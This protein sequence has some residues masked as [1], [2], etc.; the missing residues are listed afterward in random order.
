MPGVATT[1]ELLE[2][3]NTLECKA[4]REVLNWHLSVLQSVGFVIVHRRS[5][6]KF[7]V[8]ASEHPFIRYAYLEG[9]RFKDQY[10]IMTKLRQ[11]FFINQALR[12]RSR[13]P[14]LH[15]GKETPWLAFS[16]TSG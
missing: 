5:N 3:L 6:Q 8:S 1:S 7:F 4:D 14:Q 15:Q 16:G 12:P 9:T 2:C 10:R 13:P 11:G